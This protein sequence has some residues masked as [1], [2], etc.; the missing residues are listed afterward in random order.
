[1]CEKLVRLISVV[2][3]SLSQKSSQGSELLELDGTC[4]II[5]FLVKLG[6]QLSLNSSH[7]EGALR[8]MEKI[9]VD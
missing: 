1:M 7:T 5:E 6:R 8:N 4:V 2:S 3:Y 9:C